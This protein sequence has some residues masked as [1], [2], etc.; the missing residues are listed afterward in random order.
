MWREASVTH[1][2]AVTSGFMRNRYIE[3]GALIVKDGGNP[4]LGMPLK[5]LV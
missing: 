5:P 2:F 4:I 1:I 3:M